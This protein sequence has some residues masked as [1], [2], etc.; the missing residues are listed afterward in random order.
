MIDL[1]E[2]EHDALR[3]LARAGSLPLEQIGTS[4][5]IRLELAGLASLSATHPQTV[6]VTAK[7]RAFSHRQ[8]FA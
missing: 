4:V 1:R 5:G 2:I 3:Q 8:V 6:S 7:G